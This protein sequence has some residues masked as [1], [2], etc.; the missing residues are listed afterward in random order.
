LRVELCFQFGQ[1]LVLEVSP[2]TCRHLHVIVLRLD[3]VDGRYRHHMHARALLDQD[4]LEVAT[5]LRRIQHHSL[6]LRHLRRRRLA[7]TRMVQGLPKTLAAER[8]EQVVDRVH[9]ERAQGELVVG[10]GED[11]VRFGAGQFDHL[12]AIELGHLDVEEHQFRLQ[13][14][15]GLDGLEAIRA[16]ADDLDVGMRCQVLAQQPARQVFVV[17]DQ[18]PHGTTPCRF[19]RAA[20]G[21]P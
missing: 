20:R 11:I 15:D 6:Q 12:E 4:P 14:A 7:R 13:L 21:L 17:H 1:R 18:Y 8:L 5:A 16:F 19:P 2:S 3:I 9:L 10:G